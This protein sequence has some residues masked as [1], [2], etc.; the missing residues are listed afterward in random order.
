LHLHART[1]FHPV[2][3]TGRPE[4]V[5]AA[6]AAA[7]GTPRDGG[8]VPLVAQPGQ[9][10]YTST[11]FW[12]ASANSGLSEPSYTNTLW[13]GPDGSGHVVST[14]SPANHD[15]T[16]APGELKLLDLTADPN[17]A[18]QQLIDRGSATGASPNPIATSSPGR[19]Q[20]TTSLIRTLQDLLT[21]SADAYLTPEQTVA[22]FDGAQSIE[23]VTTQEG[24]VDPLGRP[25]TRLSFII[26]YNTAAG[27]RV[28]WYFD[29]QTKQFM[30]QVWVSGSTQV[31]SAM[32]VVTSGIAGSANDVPSPDA[33]YV[34]TGNPTPDFATG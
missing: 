26:D 24:V 20:D 32:L 29:A 9:Y 13:V 23:G 6:L 17:S 28:D 33:S 31:H 3:G 27:D 1:R 18:I 2:L 10:Y 14:G 16:Y 8:S 30:G 19:S 22:I 5:V 25:A 11:A 34:P 7:A 12:D 21:L 4:E 15:T